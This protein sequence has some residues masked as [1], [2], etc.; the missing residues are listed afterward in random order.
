H[1][2]PGMHGATEL[3]S[4]KDRSKPAEEPGQVNT[5]SRKQSQEEEQRHHPMENARVY[6]MAEQLSAIDG[7]LAH[8]FETLASLVVKTLNRAGHSRPPSLVARNL[9][10]RAEFDAGRRP[11]NGGKRLPCQTRRLSQARV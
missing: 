1:A 5:E 2:E 3:A 9:V 11:R 7:S 4:T 6:G 8:G 10:A